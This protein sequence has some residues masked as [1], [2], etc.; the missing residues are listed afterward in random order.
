VTKPAVVLLLVLVAAPPAVALLPYDVG[1]V[2][3]A[4]LSL[5]WWYAGAVAPILAVAITALS[6]PSSA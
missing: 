5:E 4:G 3:L 1:A 2:R 6:T